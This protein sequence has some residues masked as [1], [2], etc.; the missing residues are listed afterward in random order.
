MILF[1]H[2][3]LSACRLKGLREKHVRS[4]RSSKHNATGIQLNNLLVLSSYDMVIAIQKMPDG[5]QI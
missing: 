3:L 4:K 1:T 2:K 5:S